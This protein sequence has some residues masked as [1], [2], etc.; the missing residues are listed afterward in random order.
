VVV[1]VSEFIK[2]GGGPRCLTLALD[3]W[4]GAADSGTRG[5]PRPTFCP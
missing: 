2:S 3:V 5:R 4:L 1:D